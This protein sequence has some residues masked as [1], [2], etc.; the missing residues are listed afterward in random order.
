T[1]VICRLL[2]YSAWW[3]R[4]SPPVRLPGAVVGHEEPVEVGV[5]HQAREA[6]E[7]PLRLQLLRCARETGPC[8]KS[9]RAADT[10]ASHAERRDV[11]DAQATVSN[12]QDVDRLRPHR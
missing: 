11:G 8:S 2:E 5:R 4:R 1:L 12:H 7:T 6:C 3:P 10:D 9:Q